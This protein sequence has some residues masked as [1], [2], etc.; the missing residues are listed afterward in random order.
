MTTATLRATWELARGRARHSITEPEIFDLSLPLRE[1]VTSALGLDAELSPMFSDYEARLPWGKSSPLGFFRSYWYW[2]CLELHAVGY[3]YHPSGSSRI[4]LEGTWA[5]D[6][7]HVDIAL[8]RLNREAMEVRKPLYMKGLLPMARARGTKSTPAAA[9]KAVTIPAAASTLSKELEQR[10][11]ES[12][13]RYRLVNAITERIMQEPHIS[14]IDW[15]GAR[16]VARLSVQL[17]ELDAM[18][19]AHRDANY[20]HLRARLSRRLEEWIADLG[21]SPSAR[22]RIGYLQARSK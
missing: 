4:K 21:L 13:A 1:L 7:W 18:G 17:E 15:L 8:N 6:D 12:A 16:E 3:R 5:G 20:A 22:A 11:P 10:F 2:C 9:S 19:A 14:D